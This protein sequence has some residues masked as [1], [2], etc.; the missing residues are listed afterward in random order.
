M[1]QLEGIDDGIVGDQ[2]PSLRHR[3]LATIPINSVT[4][5]ITCEESERIIANGREGANWAGVGSPDRPG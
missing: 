1:A 5:V 4:L 2:D 3:R